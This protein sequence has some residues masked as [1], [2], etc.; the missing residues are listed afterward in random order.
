MRARLIVF[1]L[2]FH[3]LMIAAGCGGRQATQ[4]DGA[5][6]AD[7]AVDGQPQDGAVP[8][9]PSIPDGY[10]PLQPCAVPGEP[11]DAKDP[12]AILPVCGADHLCHPTKLQR[13]DDGLDCTEDS[14]VGQGVCE[15]KPKQDYCAVPAEEGGQLAFK[16][17]TKGT[18]DPQ[19]QCMA[20]E[21]ALDPYGYSPMNGGHCD[22][23]NGC[24]KD[25]YCLAGVC[26]GTY[27]GNL[28]ADNLACTDDL[29]DGKG[30]CSGSVLKSDWCLISGV[31]Y[32]DGA[33]NNTGCSV[34][35]AS[36]NTTAWTPITPDCVINGLCY[37]TGDTDPT[38]CMACDPTQST[39]AWTMLSGV[40][41]IGSL[42]YQKG[43]LH[44]GGCAEC[45]PAV[46]T[47]SWTVIGAAC[48]I[49]DMCYKS[50]DPE[51]ISNCASC[52]PTVSKTSWTPLTGMCLITTGLIPPPPPPAPPPP[53]PG[54]QCVADGT[55][56]TGGCAK[57]DVSVSTTSWT[58]TGN[59]CLISDQ[60]YATGATDSTGCAKCDP[61]VSTTSW[62][63]IANSCLIGGKCYS[64]GQTDTSGCLVCD[65]AANPTGWTPVAGVTAQTEG[66]ESGAATG[67]TI[68]NSDANV[69]WQVSSKKAGSGTYALYYGNPATGNFD[70]GA[71]NN[72]TAAMPAL[73]LTA[74]KKASLVFSLWADIESGTSFDQ[75]TVMVNGATLWMMDQ[76]TPIVMQQWTSVSVDLSTYA[77]A[78][79]TIQFKFDTMDSIANETEGLYLDD[80]TI[81]HGC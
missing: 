13:C 66:F 41:K 22:D 21:P 39:T 8:D 35:D 9:L 49:N 43:D 55:L 48:L 71:A 42:C 70:N 32:Q 67:W 79:V 20:C 40:C 63:P 1:V 14:C 7:G 65:A 56:K 18:K 25:D 47:T 77:G 34:C 17:V 69:G 33:K 44:T 68:T 5:P 45:N 15:Y 19:D 26:K 72:G 30:G 57:C 10:G 64:N 24:T 12:C 6:S 74:G 80:V 62:T 11:C 3:S 76:V 59:G 61:T 50:G 75:L 38:G 37:Q 23:N 58:P 73:T 2:F 51:P 31:C 27:Y 60:C 4:S 81:Y 78:Q 16:C 28:C 46:S 54:V 53:P 36:T 52:D 29:C